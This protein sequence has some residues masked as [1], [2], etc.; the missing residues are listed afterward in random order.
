MSQPSG[1]T[2]AVA[3]HH[4]LANQAAM[5]RARRKA[6]QQ[7]QQEREDMKEALRHALNLANYILFTVCQDDNILKR[8]E[9][10][11]SGLLEARPVLVAC[12]A[13]QLLHTMPDCQQLAKLA[14]SLIHSYVG[15]IASYIEYTQ[16]EPAPHMLQHMQ[17]PQ[18]AA[19]MACRSWGFAWW[20]SRRA[21]PPPPPGITMPH[22][23]LL[24]H[25]ETDVPRTGEMA[26]FLLF[27]A[28]DVLIAC[29]Y[30]QPGR[31]LSSWGLPPISVVE[32]LAVSAARI[33]LLVKEMLLVGGEQEGKVAPQ[34]ISTLGRACHVLVAVMSLCCSPL[35]RGAAPPNMPQQGE[36]E[37]LFPLSRHTWKAVLHVMEVLLYS[38]AEEQGG[39]EEV[40]DRVLNRRVLKTTLSVETGAMVFS[41]LRALEFSDMEV[42]LGAHP[43]PGANMELVQRTLMVIESAMRY[44]A[45]AAGWLK[46]EDSLRKVVEAENVEHAYQIMLVALYCWLAS[47]ATCTAPYICP[48]K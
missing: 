15:I 18:V 11:F 6:L 9:T 48:G 47:A 19:T 44:A 33:A 36:F 40:E 16:Q 29:V 3:N 8:C 17:H 4:K 30:E 41:L 14:S 31:T 13:Y 23:S 28:T 26:L 25:G 35:S 2:E 43:H 10:I 21:A 22:L 7:Q 24:E 5:R 20:G 1:S 37:N 27:N 38:A 12:Q 39:S 46:T 34:T 45:H 42:A 32:V